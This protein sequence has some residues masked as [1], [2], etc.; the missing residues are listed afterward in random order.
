MR[1]GVMG[2]IHGNYAGVGVALEQMGKIDLLLFTG[3]GLREIERLQQETGLSVRGVRGNCDF[4]GNLPEEICFDL[5][6]HRLLLTH[7]HRY[8]VKNGL[9]RLALMGEER[10]V[11]LVV[12]GHTHEAQLTQWHGLMLFNPGTLSG[13]IRSYGLIEITEQGIRPEL[14]RI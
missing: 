10:G 12:F 8:G 3:D 9:L 14:C 13:N 11:E 5:A 6:G 2:D 7:G 4:L 1:V